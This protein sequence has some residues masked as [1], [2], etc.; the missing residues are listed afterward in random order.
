LEFFL[1]HFFGV[2]YFNTRNRGYF[3]SKLHGRALKEAFLAIFE[4]EFLGEF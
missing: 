4:R 2:E 3:S 1:S